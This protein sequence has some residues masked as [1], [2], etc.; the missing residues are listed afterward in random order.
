MFC[1]SV[2]RISIT[3]VTADISLAKRSVLNNPSKRAIIERSNTRSSLG[4]LHKYGSA[5]CSQ[6]RMTPG[7]F[8]NVFSYL[9]PLLNGEVMID[10]REWACGE[11]CPAATRA[12]SLSA[13]VN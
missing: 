10:R 8:V 7:V 13:P 9:L 6:T 11:T 2:H 3:R 12:C 5:L 4:K 1:A